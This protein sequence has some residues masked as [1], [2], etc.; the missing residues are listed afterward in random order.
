MTDECISFRNADAVNQMAVCP[1]IAADS[2]S[3][4]SDSPQNKEV[5]VKFYFSEKSWLIYL[6][7]LLN[8]QGFKD[9][10]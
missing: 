7:K 1:G 6:V 2:P 8:M 5:A 3:S 10:L 4:T 9:K